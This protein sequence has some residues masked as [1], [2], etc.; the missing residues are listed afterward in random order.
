M[1]PSVS[2][3]KES[4]VGDFFTAHAADYSTLFLDKPSGSNFV[5]RE[6]LSLASQLTSE[7]SG[8]ILDCACGSGEVT[9]SV[10]G[11][12]QF[13]SALLVD[14]SPRM[15]EM[16]RQRL[17]GKQKGMSSISMEFRNQDIFE[18]VEKSDSEKFDVIL[19]L[20]LIAHT[21]RLSQLLGGL[22]RLL[23]PGGH[24]LLQSTLLDHPGTRLFRLVASRRYYRR[25]GY[26]ISYYRHAEI[27]RVAEAE[28][29][30]MV[31]V[32][33][34][35]FGFPF[36]DRIWARMNYRLEQMAR[37][38]ARACGAEALY[39]LKARDEIGA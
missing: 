20:G 28:G 22:R 9:A 21:G 7:L 25:Q 39:L 32:K 10:L 8:R 31:Q 34:F 26:R 6:R 29:F 2:N 17:A 1:I 36:G 3:P 14:L 12:G 16:A 27:V 13:G 23:S 18:F 38:W 37:N 11:S 33:R 24:V 19:C 35:G 4:A 30:D 5:F 15:L